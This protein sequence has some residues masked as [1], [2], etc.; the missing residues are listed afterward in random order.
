M[1]DIEL[2][3]SYFRKYISISAADQQIIAALCEEVNVS[4][5][6][7]VL[8]AGEVCNH[9][10]FVVKGIF[11]YYMN[12]DGTDRTYNFVKEGDFVCDYD[13]LIRRAPSVKN[14]EALEPCVVLRISLSNLQKLYRELAE[15]ERFGRLHTERIYIDMVRQLISQYTQ[16]PE[17]RYQ[18][19]IQQ[20]PDL[21]QRLPQYYIASYVGVKPQSLSRIRKRMATPEPL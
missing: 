11:R 15:G 8:N 21:V 12:Q 5:S 9:L 7:H 4:K 3:T 19:F 20:H 13:S 17:E 2:L 14:I 1:Q 18:K 16:S 6:D 10:H